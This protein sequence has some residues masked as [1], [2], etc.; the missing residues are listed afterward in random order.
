[1][2][3]CCYFFLLQQLA[4][5]VCFFGHFQVLAWLHVNTISINSLLVS[6]EADPLALGN[7]RTISPAYIA[8]FGTPIAS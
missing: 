8:S 6:K 7:R 2:Y 4:S 1:V 5:L 3:F